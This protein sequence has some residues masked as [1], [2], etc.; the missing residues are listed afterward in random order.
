MMDLSQPWDAPILRAP[1]IAIECV[2]AVQT[3][4]GQICIRPDG[5]AVIPDGL[6][7]DAALRQFWN[8]LAIVA[9]NRERCI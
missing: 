4:K 9:T 6:P 3:P 1:D 2:I 5:K 8:E 7:I